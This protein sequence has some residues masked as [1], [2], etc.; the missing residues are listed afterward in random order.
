M[1]FIARQEPFDCGQCGLHVEP[2]EDGSYRNHCPKCL[3]SKHVDKDGPGDRLSE[4]KSMMKPI[5]VDYKKKK[6]WMIVHLC[7]SC[8]KEI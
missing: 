5:G 2:L 7:E 8:G 3:W 1:V 4:C 6:G